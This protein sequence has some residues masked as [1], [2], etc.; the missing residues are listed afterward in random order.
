MNKEEKEV[1]EVTL[2]AIRTILVALENDEDLQTMPE[3]KFLE[4]SFVNDLQMDSLE[5]VV[6]QMEIEKECEVSLIDIPQKEL[7][8]VKTVQDFLNLCKKHL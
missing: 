3:D 1:K 5:F 2:D 4:Q 6:F 8:Q 7:E